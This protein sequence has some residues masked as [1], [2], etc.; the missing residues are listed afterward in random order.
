M[1]ISGSDFED[2]II[3]AGSDLEC[4]YE[5]LD[6]GNIVLEISVPCIGSTFN[7]DRNFYSRQ[8][9][10]MDYSSAAAMVTEEGQRTMGRLDEIE[11]VV[12]DPKLEQARQKLETALSLDEN[13]TEI[14][15]SQEAME[16]VYEAKKLL[17][18]VRKEHLKEI[19]QLELDRTVEFFNGHLRQYARPSEENAFD[20][21]TK[22]AQRAIERND[23]AFENHHRELTGKNIE[24]L[25]RQDWF[26]VARF[27]K[28]VGSPHLF[29]DQSK[30]IELVR[31]GNEFVR[32]EDID[33]VRSVIAQLFS[34]Q[35]S[36]SSV[37]D[38]F[39][40]A[41]IIRG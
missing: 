7:S 37:D 24:L 25:W 9:G 4:E 39:D 29:T 34:I 13:E 20:N 28:M 11:D 40:A 31:V 19:R 3:P 41:N 21:L 23:K 33:G 32:K 5:I 8:E 10:Q 38:M 36:D 18:Q 2:G 12:E 17:A 16:K 27:N 26:V 22:I 35:I 30:F 15:K 6:S 14:E 1:K